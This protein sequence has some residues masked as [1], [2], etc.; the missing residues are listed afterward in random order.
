M[1]AAAALAWSFS[2]NMLPD[3]TEAPI[4]GRTRQCIT[5]HLTYLSENFGKGIFT[6]VAPDSFLPRETY[7][8]TVSISQSGLRRWG[9]EMTALTGAGAMAGQFA[10]TDTT[11]LTLNG[12]VPGVTYVAQDGHRGGTF[13]GNTS[14]ATWHVDWTAPAAGAGAVTFYAAGVAADRNSAATGDYVYTRTHAATE[15]RTPV[16]PTSWGAIKARYLSPREP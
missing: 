2:S 11:V 10:L 6:V 3:G 14:G 1:I 4:E 5:C 13:D 7:P 12:S 9:F 16:T 15:G 8:I